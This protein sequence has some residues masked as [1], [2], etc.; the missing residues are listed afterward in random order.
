MILFNGRSHVDECFGTLLQQSRQADEILAIDNGS[1][2]GCLDLVK[3]RFSTVR[4]IRLDSNLGYA[5]GCN[6]AAREATSD[7]VVFLN[8][9]V[10]LDPNWL[11]ELIRPLESDASVIASQSMVLLYDE[12]A[13]VNTSSTAV[14]FLGI[15]WV[16]DYRR[17][18]GEVRSHDIPFLSGAAFA[19]RRQSFLAIGGFDSGYGSYHEDVDLSWRM[20]LTR[21]RI[22]LAADSR[23]YHKY[24]FTG[25]GTK[26]YLLER[27]RVATL[28]KNYRG[29]SLWLMSPALLFTEAGVC[30]LALSQG[31]LD[32]K[33]KSY[34]DL[35]RMRQQ[36]LEGRRQ[37]QRLRQAPDREI[38]RALLGGIHFEE[39]NRGLVR[40]GSAVLAAYWWVARR[41]IAW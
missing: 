17:P 15:A 23:V 5:G 35:Y 3:A 41:L 40:L 21:Q 4:A 20:R 34:R 25:S 12:P 22:V 31:W 24:K 28:L 13:L 38:A 36:I 37:A 2:D 39:V 8:Q 7:L 30:L 16:S 26:N 14:N 9:D 6:R 29:L 11:S 19:I 1:V 27:N 33:V 18:A 10:R 32:L